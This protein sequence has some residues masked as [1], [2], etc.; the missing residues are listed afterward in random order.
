MCYQN[1]CNYCLTVYV[2][3]PQWMPEAHASYIITI[4]L[5]LFSV[6]AIK[7]RFL[8]LHYLQNLF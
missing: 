7:S 3:R 1:I 5:L 4:H 2:L 6:F 8:D